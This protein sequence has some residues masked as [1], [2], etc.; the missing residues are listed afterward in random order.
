MW[1]LVRGKKKHRK[2]R[3]T[4]SANW[5]L[6]ISDQQKSQ[7][8]RWLWIRQNRFSRRW[9]KNWKHSLVPLK[10][11]KRILESDLRLY[12][13]FIPETDTSDSWD[14][15]GYSSQ[16][17]CITSMYFSLAVACTFVSSTRVPCRCLLV[18][19]IRMISPAFAW[20]INSGKSVKSESGIWEHNVVHESHKALHDSG[21]VFE[22]PI[23][24]R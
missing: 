19:W 8:Q 21:S 23:I 14:I 3:A 18:I 5:F 7:F 20:K 22:S 2:G 12:F 13:L 11:W 1:F 16:K 24:Q 6:N 17:R 10:W 4:M 15:P 9:P